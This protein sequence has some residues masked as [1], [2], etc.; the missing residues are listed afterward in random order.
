MSYT[1]REREWD[2]YS[3][4]S[5]SR[6]SYTIKRYVIPTEEDEREVIWRRDDSTS[7]ERDL[8]TRRKKDW[9]EAD[10]ETRR[11][12]RAEID[13][14]RKY[15]EPYHL[16]RFLWSEEYIMLPEKPPNTSLFPK[17]RQ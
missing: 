4:P 14:E 1:Y 8:V 16:R 15:S 2:E 11:D 9:D 6:D 13:Y 10:Y 7:D 17:A 12:Y 3:R 5:E